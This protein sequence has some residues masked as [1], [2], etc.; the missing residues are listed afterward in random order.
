[1]AVA[2]SGEDQHADRGPAEAQRMAIGVT[3]ADA[4]LTMVIPPRHAAAEGRPAGN[5][6]RLGEERLDTPEE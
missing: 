3:P 5:P 6:G 1:M 2:Q 4:L